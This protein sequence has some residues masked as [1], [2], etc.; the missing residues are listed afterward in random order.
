MA[1]LSCSS[2]GQHVWYLWRLIC[3]GYLSRNERNAASVHTPKVSASC[4]SSVLLTSAG[5]PAGRRSSC[6]MKPTLRSCLSGLERLTPT[7][8][9]LEKPGGM[10]RTGT[11]FLNAASY[12]TMFLRILPDLVSANGLKRSNGVHGIARLGLVQHQVRSSSSA[13]LQNLERGNGCVVYRDKKHERLLAGC[14]SSAHSG[15]H[16]IVAGLIEAGHDCALRLKCLF[17]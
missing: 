1:L 11:F 12:P 4:P 5:M 10:R 9:L 15:E 3:R 17:H 13:R 14:N 7:S 8:S 6:P 16:G 2:W